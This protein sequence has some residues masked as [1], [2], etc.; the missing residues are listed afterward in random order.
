MLFDVAFSLSDNEAVAWGIIFGQ[1]DGGKWD[2]GRMAWSPPD[3]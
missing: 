3:K 2:W 1:M